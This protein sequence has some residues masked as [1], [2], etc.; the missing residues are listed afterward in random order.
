MPQHIFIAPDPDDADLLVIEGIERL[1]GELSRYVGSSRL[2]SG[3]VGWGYPVEREGWQ[4]LSVFQAID[5][6]EDLCGRWSYTCLWV[7]GS[8]SAVCVND[9]CHVGVDR[10]LLCTVLVW[11]G[12]V[13][14]VDIAVEQSA[15]R[16]SVGI[17]V[18]GVGLV[19][20]LSG[21]LGLGC[22]WLC[23]R[24]GWFLTGTRGARS[25]SVG[26]SRLTRGWVPW[27][28]SVR[29]C[30]FVWWG[31]F[32]PGVRLLDGFCGLAVFVP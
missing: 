18:V 12:G 20:M 32:G 23:A 9:T 8:S 5:Q 22:G 17:W 24:G 16:V 11:L 29:C 13:E 26:L 3:S 31:W 25:M 30:G 27:R 2:R 4:V 10:I 15:L 28:Q 7:V 19:V 14:V 6:L 1:R 21:V